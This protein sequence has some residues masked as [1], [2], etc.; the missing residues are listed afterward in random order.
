MN[1]WNTFSR[2]NAGLLDR[3]IAVLETLSKDK[4]QALLEFLRE[5]DQASISEICHATG[6][7]ERQVELQI[8]QI[9]Q[10]GAL[11][12]IATPGGQAFLLNKVRLNEIST[13][14]GQI[15][16]PGELVSMF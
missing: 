11:D 8:H 5:S 10:T 15:Q 9:R 2:G 12:V 16:G 3:A 14:A 1:T 7:P 13:I 4:N 6:L